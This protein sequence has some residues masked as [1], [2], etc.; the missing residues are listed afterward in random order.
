M[1]SSERQGYIIRFLEAIFGN[2][3]RD[4]ADAEDHVLTSGLHELSFFFFFSKS[5]HET[6]WAT[7]GSGVLSTISDIKLE[8]S[9]LL[10]HIVTSIYCQAKIMTGKE[11]V[12]NDVAG[13]RR[14][15]GGGRQ[16]ETQVK[17]IRQ[18]GHVSGG[19]SF[20]NR[21]SFIM[22]YSWMNTSLQLPISNLMVAR[23][24]KVF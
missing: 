7:H 4:D 12:Q 8:I 15:G 13:R 17:G 18:D 21:V 2:L 3:C 6:Q 23:K 14:G 19:S 5:K 22:S 9:S 11:K 24:S 10:R 20:G 16:R 1:S